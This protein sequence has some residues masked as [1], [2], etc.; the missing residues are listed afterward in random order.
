MDIATLEAQE[1]RLV[2]P[3]FDETTAWALGQKLVE[4]G[5]SRAHPIVI[6]IRTLNRTLFH[7]ALPGSTPLNDKWAAR[8]SNTCL[9]FQQASFLVGSRM[10]AK[11]GNLA[12]HGCD[13]E[14]YSE[15]G[16]SFPIRVAGTGIVAAVTVSGLPQEEDHSL[17]VEALTALLFPPA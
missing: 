16:G 3:A 2:F 13:T 11:G 12:V 5:L 17:V 4:L 7:A 15:S 8:K 1:Q 14:N 9:L 10:R 6:N